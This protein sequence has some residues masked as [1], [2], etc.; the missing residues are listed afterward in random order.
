MRLMGS[1]LVV[2][3][4]CPLV[5]VDYVPGLHM[6]DCSS[7]SAGSRSIAKARAEEICI[8]QS[9]T[10]SKCSVGAHYYYC[11]KVTDTHIDTQRTKVIV[12]TARSV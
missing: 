4:L 10:H 1:N 11:P 9:L 3:R 12:C 6:D 5:G 7:F 2:R 8:K